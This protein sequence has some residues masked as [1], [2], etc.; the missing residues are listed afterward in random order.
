MFEDLTRS[1]HP[2]PA[3]HSHSELVDSSEASNGDQS[4]QAAPL[5]PV[6]ASLSRRVLVIEDN[7]DAAEAFGM[8]LEVIGH[9]VR[10]AHSG[11]DGVALAREWQ[12]EIV[13]SDI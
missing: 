10:I 9:A 8:F 7:V 13:L 11:R 2:V 4:S 3:S 5:T 6:E 12:P 1:G